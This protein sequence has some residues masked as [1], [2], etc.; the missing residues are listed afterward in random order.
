VLL[1][2]AEADPAWLRLVL[3]DRFGACFSVPSVRAGSTQMMS[4]PPAIQMR[5]CT[6]F[7]PENGAIPNDV[8][9]H[10]DYPAAFTV[11]LLSSRVAMLLH[12]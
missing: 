7:M 5:I 3:Y 9:S 12:S 1:G 2:V 10:R 11:R 8:P 4:N 6:S